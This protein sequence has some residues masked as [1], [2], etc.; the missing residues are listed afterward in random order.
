MKTQIKI[1]IPQ[2]GFGPVDVEYRVNG[3]HDKTLYTFTG[4]WPVYR[5]ERG[6]QLDAQAVINMN[7]QSEIEELII[8]R[9]QSN[10]R[11][12]IETDAINTRIQKPES[13]KKFQL[14]R[15]PK[16]TIPD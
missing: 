11:V 3:C 6:D 15:K 14:N 16:H 1:L 8:Q 10:H 2:F 9:T 13:G 4:F 5:G 7:G 12:G